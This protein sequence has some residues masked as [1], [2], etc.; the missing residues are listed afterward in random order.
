MIVDCHVHLTRG[1]GGVAERADLLIR[2]ADKFRIDKLCLSL[3]WKLIERP[4]PQEFRECND[5]VF[6]AMRL[7]PDRFVGFC[8]VNPAHGREALEEIRRCVADGSMLGIKLWCA[9]PCSDPCVFPIIERAIELGAPVL[10]HTWLKITGNLPF[11]S[12]PSDMVRLASA[13]PQAKIIFGHA[14][15][16]WEHGI[17]AVKPFPNVFIETAGGNPEAGFT[18]MA[19]REVGARRVVF[20]S[21]AGGRSYASQIAKVYGA[22]IS[23]GERELILG[24]NMKRLLKI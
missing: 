14:G 5:L 20:G 19:V 21:D 17:K 11:E 8:Y 3:G 13:Y 12:R 7:H 1:P 24:Q 10:Q 4:S 16:D 6:E 23:E 22:D 15:G 9:V 2:Y 18:E